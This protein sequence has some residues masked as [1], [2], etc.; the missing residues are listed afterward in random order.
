MPSGGRQLRKAI[1]YRETA[2]VHSD[3][4][5]VEKCFIEECHANTESHRS[6]V[7]RGVGCEMQ[8]DE[9][10]LPNWLKNSLQKNNIFT[11]WD[12]TNY[13]SAELRKCVG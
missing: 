5:M 8:I 12:L 9:M 11:V 10:N 6:L 3:G 2:A 1:F 13:S 7:L 4:R